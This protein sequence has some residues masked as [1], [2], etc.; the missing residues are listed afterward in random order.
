MKITDVITHQRSVNVDEP[1]TSSR[2]WVS[3]T[4][5]A[6]VVEIKTDE[7]ITGGGDCYGASAVCKSIEPFSIATG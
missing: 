1:F 4:K 7:G 6:L 5:G 2:G 3:K